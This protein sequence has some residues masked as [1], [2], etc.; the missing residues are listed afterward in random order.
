VKESETWRLLGFVRE[1]SRKSLPPR[2]MGFTP[3]HFLGD[4]LSYGCVSMV[5]PTH[6]TPSRTFSTLP[7]DSI[8]SD[9][10]CI[11]KSCDCDFCD[12][13]TLQ[14][15][16]RFIINI[17][18]SH[19]LQRISSLRPNFFHNIRRRLNIAYQPYTCAGISD[20]PPMRTPS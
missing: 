15:C 1:H 10:T 4:G 13:V 7:L 5:C 2:L 18:I 12:D 9:G 8:L 19:A 20:H 11:M 14:P 17:C 6:F 16:C 3:T